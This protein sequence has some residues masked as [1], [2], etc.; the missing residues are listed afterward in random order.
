MSIQPLT[1]KGARAVQ[2]STA[3]WNIY[4]GAVR[5]GKT[6]SSLFAW[7][8]YVRKGPAGNLAM[9][10]KTE[11]TLKRNVIDPLIEMVGS[12]RCRYVAGAG[13][14]YL[15]GRRIYVAGAN[16]IKAVEKIQGLTLA[17]AYGDEVATW[18][19]ELWKMLGTRFSVP[20]AQFFGTCNPAGPVHWL[21]L[22]L[23]RA[24]LWIAHDGTTSTGHSSDPIDLHRFSFVIEDNEHLDPAFVASLKAQ[25]VGLFFKRYILGLWVPAEGA[26]YDMFDQDRH[27][28][29][30]L[31]R[32]E[33]W[34]GLG[35]DHGTRNPFHAVLLGLGVDRRLHITREWRWDSARQR[36]QLSDAEYS[37]ELRQWLT[38]VPVPTT[39]L[40]G[41][42]PERTIVDP[43]A[44]GF[45][46]QLHQDGMPTVV[47]D[48]EVLPGIRTVQSLYALDLLDIHESCPEL[49]RETIGYSWS[50]KA[51]E[52]GLDEPIKKADHGPDAKR[53]DI[54]TTRGQW[55]PYLRHQLHIA[56]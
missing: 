18:P 3:R 39:A 26:V 54:R 8:R 11:R 38:T 56:A 37:R 19:E 17:G 33:R 25:Y 46:V 12:K 1:G 50:D 4:E 15:F 7:M 53:Y 40:H 32:I 29:S 9:I 47:A 10:G 41:V 43:S 36:R 55:R 2:L 22:W 24:A 48:N 20:G 44:T 42:H 21:K 51:A 35:I 30:D 45:R 5:S 34:L 28:V 27:V 14:L 23:D 13:E 16:D 49:I 52:Q 6:I 31:P